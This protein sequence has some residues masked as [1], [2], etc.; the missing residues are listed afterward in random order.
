M[1]ESWDMVSKRR[2]YVETNLVCVQP[3]ARR[4]ASASACIVSLIGGF[5]GGLV[6]K[7]LMSLVSV[8]ALNAVVLVIMPLGVWFFSRYTVTSGIALVDWPRTVLRTDSAY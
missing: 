4:Y 1:F 7:L 3:T 6:G 8:R 5:F 2:E